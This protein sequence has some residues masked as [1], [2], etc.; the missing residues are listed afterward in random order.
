LVFV[1]ISLRNIYVYATAHIY[2]LCIY[3]VEAFEFVYF[4]FGE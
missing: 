4:G 1:G 2:D 3:S